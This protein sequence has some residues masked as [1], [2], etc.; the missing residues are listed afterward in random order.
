MNFVESPHCSWRAHCQTCRA[1]T[2][3]GRAFRVSLGQAFMLPP[4]APD[5]PCPHG[6]PWGYAGEWLPDMPSRGLGDTVAK[7]THALG[8]MPCGGC[9]ERQE[10]ANKKVP[11]EQAEVAVR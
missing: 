5:F 4:G 1:Q 6:R 10:W 11:Y 3:A 2:E 9:R 7:I 8:I